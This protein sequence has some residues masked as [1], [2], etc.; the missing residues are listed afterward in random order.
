MRHFSRLAALVCIAALSFTACQ[1]NSELDVVEQ[2]PQTVIDQIIDMGFDTQGAEVVAEGYRVEGDIIIRPEDLDSHWGHAH[3]GNDKQYA[4]NN[5][6]STSGNRVITVYIPEGTSGR[7][8]NKSSGFNANY[9]AALD[10]ALGRFN[11]ENLAISF[12]RVTSSSADIVFTRLGKRDERRGVLGSAGFPT[13]G[14][15]PYNQVRMS[16]IIDTNFG[17]SRSAIATVMAHELGHC[18]GFRHTD[19]FDRS[20]SC[21]GGFSN[22]GASNVGANHI[23]GTPTGA[24][25]SDKSWMLACTGNENRPF[26]NDD[27]AALNFLY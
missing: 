25:A 6:V 20:I 23:P 16:G 14:G 8:K 12:Q 15:D 18:I 1:E 11:A 21:G 4:T 27:K 3:K 22:E 2:V 24:S 26:N 9:V 10:D 17:W 7:G 19:Y 13:A 5:L